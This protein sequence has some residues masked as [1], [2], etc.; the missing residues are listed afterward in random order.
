MSEIKVMNRARLPIHG[1]L[2]WGGNQ[3]QC[4]NDL[5]VGS[6]HEFHVGLGGTDIAIVV[7]SKGSKFD[8]KNNGN[9]DFSRLLLQ[10]LAIGSFALGGPGG[11]VG[12]MMVAEEIG[13]DLWRMDV[14]PSGA[15]EG[16]E[17]TITA[18]PGLKVFPVGET[19]LYCPDGYDVTIT[20]GEMTGKFDK[21]SKTFT[22]NQVKP[23]H[24]HWHNKTSGTSGDRDAS[25]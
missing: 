16:G 7:G 22:V 18:A 5:S 17:I 20:G 14:K 3:M 25:T 13:M 2:T 6:D 12:I 19:G 11:F 23:L 15:G 24:L 8:S 9:I 1:V 4:F 10:G 21:A